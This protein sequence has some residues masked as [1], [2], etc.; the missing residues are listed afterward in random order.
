MDENGESVDEGS[1]S[2]SDDDEDDIPVFGSRR[3]GKVLRKIKRRNR[4]LED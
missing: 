4:P 2:D 1:S 3:K